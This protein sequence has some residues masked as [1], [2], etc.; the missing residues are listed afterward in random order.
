MSNS[1]YYWGGT[2]L[3][4][5]SSGRDVEQW[6]TFL[7]NQGY[8]TGAIDGIFGSVTDAA[9]KAYQ[10]AMGLTEDGISG[11][12]TMSSAGFKN[13]NTPVGAPTYKPYDTT[14]WNDTQAGKDSLKAKDD[15]AAALTGKGPFVWDN[16]AQYDDLYK[17][18]TE[19]DPFSYDFNADALYHQYK[20]M[21][22]KQ[23]Q[24]AMQDTMGQA[25]AMTGGYGNSYA[26]TVGNQAYQASLQQLN[27]VIPEL[28]QLALSKYSMEGQDMLNA[29]GLMESDR[30]FDY[31]LYT[32]EYGRLGDAY[33]IAS[34]NY[35]TGAN[36]HYTDL[37]NI[38]AGIDREN[39]N[40]WKVADWEET[41]RRDARDAA[42]KVTTSGPVSDDDGK[43]TPAKEDDDIPEV[44][45]SDWDVGDW[46]S[47]F[48][49]IRHDEGREAAEEELNY[50]S[51]NGLI[52]TGMFTY[53]ALGARGQLGH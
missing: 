33:N 10:K 41:Q 38:N 51:K 1:T 36:M 17:K 43:K 7:K 35:T 31:G 19:R 9:T 40:S 27:G 34:D 37:G 4:S 18:Y 21:Y 50:F 2:D 25:A 47:Y 48:A 39:D 11:I 30:A 28:Y 22:M 12:K 15:A 26:V 8:Y 53:A 24:M 3:K 45:Y 29:L 16:Q 23:G 52:P 46:N 44:D 14:S 32:D 13:Y 5:G 49:Q 42:T 6:Q 20:D